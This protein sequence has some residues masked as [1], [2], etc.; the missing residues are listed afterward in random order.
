MNLVRRLTSVSDR[1][2]GRMTKIGAA[3]LVIGVPVFA[4]FYYMDTHVDS[5]P[6]LTSRRLSA[7]EQAV[8]KAPRNLS[9]RL[10]LAQAYIEAGKD[11]KALAQYDEVLSADPDHRVAL[12]ARGDLLRRR[13]DLTGATAMYTT[14]IGPAAKGEFAGADTDLGAAYY[15]L[16]AVQ[17]EQG[18][19]KQ[20][21][22][23]LQH[24]V[25]IESTDADAWYLMASALLKAGAPARAV[26][27]YRRA[28]LFVPTG[29]CEPYVG[30]QT[31]YRRI[32]KEPLARYAG[33]M[34]GFCDGHADSARAELTAL[35]TGPAALDAMLGLGMIAEVQADRT[36]A[37]DWY[38]RAL[39]IDHSNITAATGL[40]RLG[41]PAPGAAHGQAAR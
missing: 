19:P 8:V 17:L 35:T 37:A 20:A 40:A 10:G 36:A 21:V 22:V 29:W 30:M 1:T 7:A 11:D 26:E 39:R 13:N 2:L 25:G 9:A 14:L 6:S 3:V 31:A 18:K 24:T 27:A 4:A 33:A 12:L 34:A 41:Q 32:G 28:V 23:T 38:R 16:A 5:G 15:G